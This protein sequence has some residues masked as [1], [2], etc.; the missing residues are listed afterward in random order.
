VAITAVD[1]LRGRVVVENRGEAVVDLGGHRLTF[2][3]V[4]PDVRPGVFPDGTTV[5]PGQSLV[6]GVGD[7]S[8]DAE[9]S[10]GV[11][12]RFEH[13]V[14]DD[15][16]NVVTIRT[17]D[18]TLVA[19]RTAGLPSPCDVTVETVPPGG[20]PTTDPPALTGLSL[21][22][23]WAS[24]VTTV[25]TELLGSSD[26]T[27]DQTFDVSTPPVV[28][29]EVWVDEQSALSERARAELT[30]TQPDAVE[31]VTGAR[32]ELREFWVRWT[33]V[34]D[35]LSVAA[36]ARAYT[37]D[38][39]TGVIAFG[40]GV[41]GAIPPIGRDNVRASYRTGG[42][43]AGN[44]PADTVTSLTSSI[45]FVDSIT[46]PEAGDGGAAA[47]STEAVLT[48]APRELRDRGRAVTPADFERVAMDASRT[49]A[50]VRCLPGMDEAGER[51]PGWVT[52][53]IVP[54]AGR[55]KPVPSVELKRQVVEAVGNDAPA[56]LTAPDRLVV[57][58][59]NY[60][61]VSVE[62]E[63]VAAGTG[64]VSTLEE[65]VTDAIDGFLHPLTGGPSGDGWAFGSL[66]CLSDLY[67]LLE[68]IDG[69]DHVAD[70][71]VRFEGSGAPITVTEGGS[72][73]SAAADALV[74]SGRHDVVGRGGV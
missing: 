64:S 22:A 21:N 7:D 46:N 55:R 5:G 35:F 66:P 47:E 33:R 38:P 25:R 59:P 30:E 16:V 70:L 53:L 24:N 61:E 51:S 28:D 68:G 4:S 10:T 73:P 74:C 42:G 52:L 32:D 26:G 17:P 67:A 14:L 2:A 69:V 6:V 58:G 37:V 18:G 60:V 34:E 41:D 15:R 45:P 56:T 49:L 29:E 39:L 71:V 63:V 20:A 1:P 62:T 9:S 23:G 11:D 27:Q 19:E 57:R 8:S 36:D 54:S 3:C 40:D 12:V 72:E 44:V 43:T 50:K 48:R 65:T 13:A 31:A